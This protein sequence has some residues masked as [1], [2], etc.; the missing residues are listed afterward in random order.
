LRRALTSFVTVAVG[1]AVLALPAA[2]QALDPPTVRVAPSATSVVVGGTRQLTATVANVTDTSVTWSV[3]HGPGSVSQTGLY[4]PPAQ[5]PA[6]PVAVVRAESV[7]APGVVGDAVVTIA[8][9]VPGGAFGAEVPTGHDGGQDTDIGDVTGDG[10]ADV[11]VMENCCNDLKVWRI[12]TLSW[13]GSGFTKSVSA[14]GNTFAANGFTSTNDFILDLEL[15]DLDEDG[16]L[17]VYVPF[18]S[19]QAQTWRYQVWRNDG[20]GTFTPDAKVPT[21]GG[22]RSGARAKL[23]DFDGDGHLDAVRMEHFG[24]LMLETGNGDGTFDPPVLLMSVFSPLGFSL[25]DLT[26]DGRPEVA[27]GMKTTTNVTQ[28]VFKVGINNG[29]GAIASE[30]TYTTGVDA[31]PTIAEVTGDGWNDLVV[32]VGGESFSNPANSPKLVVFANQ[33]TGTGAAGPASTLAL[34]IRPHDLQAVHVDDDGLLDLAGGTYRGPVLMRRTGAGT[35]S[36]VHAASL[37]LRPHHVTIGDVTGDGRVDAFANGDDDSRFWPGSADPTVAFA[38][39][40]DVT[41]VNA[42]LTAEMS[43]SLRN[44]TA[45]PKLTWTASRGTFGGD[46]FDKSTYTA[47]SSASPSG[48]PV[49]ITATITGTSTKATRTI[50]VMNDKFQG[51]SPSAQSTRQV[52]RDPGS[53]TTLYAATAGGVYRSTNGGASFALLGT[54]TTTGTDAKALTVV[55]DGATVRVLAV[56]GTTL[57]KYDLTTVTDWVSTGVTS[58]AAVS[59]AAG[60]SVAFATS[61]GAVRV[62]TDGGDTFS[63]LTG[64]SL[65]AANRVEAIDGTSFWATRTSAPYVVSGAVSGT[66]LTLTT[67]ETP[68]AS[69]ANALAVDPD[70]RAV[71]YV[72]TTDAAKPLYRWDGG[73]WTALSPP[74]VVDRLAVSPTGALLALNTGGVPDWGGNAIYKS[75]DGGATW[76]SLNRGFPNGTSLTTVAHRADGLDV[77]GTSGGIYTPVEQTPPAAPEVTAGPSGTTSPGGANAFSFTFGTV[78]DAASYLCALDDT[79]WAA[80]TSPKT[81]SGPLGDG[82]HTFSVVALDA[83]GNESAPGTRTWTVD[84]TPAPVPSITSGPTGLVNTASA[85]FEF[86]LSGDAVS[87]TCALDSATP[88]SCTTG[89]SYTS[90]SQGAHTFSVRSVDPAGN[91]SA[92]ATRTWTVDTVAP[93]WPWFWSSPQPVSSSSSAFF[94]WQTEGGATYACTLDDSPVPCS[95]FASLSDL[96]EGNHTF[97][98]VATDAA[99]NS[100]GNQHTWRVDLTDPDAPVITAKPDASTTAT[101]AAFTFASPSNDVS[102]YLCNLDNGGWFSCYGSRDYTS[103]AVGAHTFSVAAVDQ[104]QRQSA[105]ATYEWTIVVAPP[106]LTGGPTGLVTSRTAA[107]TFTGLDGATFACS[108]DGATPVSCVSGVTYTDL[109][110]GAHTFAVTQTKNGATSAATT[111][112]WTVD[113][114]APA[115][116]ELTAVPPLRTKTTTAAFAWTPAEGLTYACALDGSPVTCGTGAYSAEGLG[117]GGHTF[118]LTARDAALNAS[119]ASYSWTVDTTGPTVSISSKPGLRVTST[120]ASFEFG[121]AASDLAGFTCTLDGLV[122][123]CTSPRTLSS[124]AQGEHTFSVV[125]VDDL[126][127]SGAAAT[128]TWTVDTAGPVVTFTAKPPPRTAQTAA[129]FD[130]GTTATDLASYSCTIDGVTGDCDALDLSSLSE[131]Q[132]SF[133]VV[134]TDDLGNPGN[135]ATWTWTIDT[136]APAVTLT[137]TP[138]LL[139]NA[140]DTSF[141]FTSA[142]TDVA[143]FTCTLDGTETACTSAYVVS[144]L[145]PGDHSFSVFATDDV[146]NDGDPVTYAWTVD[147]AAP[148]TTITTP[149][150]SLKPSHVVSWNEPVTDVTTGTVRLLLTGTATA[151]PVSLTCR[152]A[153][154]ATVACASGSTR[155][156]VLVPTAPLTPG[157]L[158]TISVSGVQDLAGNAATASRGYRA[159]TSD[160]ENGLAAKPAWRKASSSVAQGGSYSVADLKGATASYSFTGT[161]VVWYGLRGPSYGTADVY[162]DDVLKAS[163]VS[164]YSTTSSALTRTISGLTNAKHVLRIVVRGEKGSTSGTGTNVAVD[165]FKVGGVVS[166]SPAV[167]F[168]WAR[169]SA[170]SAGGGAYAIEDTAGATF[171]LSFRGRTVDWVTILGPSMGKASVTIDGV[172]KGT[173]DNWASATRYGYVRRFGGLTD[174]VHTIKITVLG[175]RRTGATGTNVVVDR[176]AITP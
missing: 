119:T 72:A 37:P 67:R 39:D 110:D 103:L 21:T 105:A 55:R 46:F 98:V 93:A 30:V 10:V 84:A 23:T 166:A 141:S 137:A 90:L 162:V 149:S 12:I 51:P 144:D 13:N 43:A 112:E 92:A 3:V 127:N 135:P 61:G 44:V 155:N 8:S 80:C 111:R 163:K 124:L 75:L 101:T 35:F 48:T 50:T 173:F 129:A 160:Q 36:Q 47:P 118:V 76:Y 140:A 40:Q 62:S 102:Y 168:A 174:K 41:R 17:D 78:A 83:N 136:T 130:W 125:G 169:R 86:T 65:T 56:F 138:A 87:A 4:T 71:A 116:P 175:T 64:A 53:A 42:T 69:P 1:A 68:A 108:L 94:Q 147:T 97:A 172:S 74:H 164:F 131:G 6:D 85:T 120:S 139:S 52:V 96:A 33:G 113:A 161:S 58:A 148:V 11:V 154:N 126:G 7:E 128:H 22:S 114:T 49:T 104:A 170:A 9:G 176:F 15:G 63:A 59:A 145:A 158:Y 132:H 95:S 106:A 16:D 152:T 151:V 89:T 88:A 153:A 107:F 25:G 165:A 167:T 143:G 45:E 29:F 54:T 123:S 77:V 150:T 133:S 18:G 32:A 146:G 142:A 24:N 159:S 26:G 91:V 79:S 115:S 109:G 122:A 82:S 34:P 5:P 28:D 117:Q 60:T 157:Q 27:V 100:T 121:S 31:E 38:I 99:G 66:A 156:V 19:A 14:P 57:Y 20:T 134:G 81:Y 2:A 171:S 73:A 70:D